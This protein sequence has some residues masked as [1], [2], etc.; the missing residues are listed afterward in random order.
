MILIGGLLIVVVIVDG[1]RRML[2]DRRNYVRMNLAAPLDDDG[3]DGGEEDVALYNPELPNGGARTVARSDAA[4]PSAAR[5][6]AAR[7]E[8]GPREGPRTVEPQLGAFD[9]DDRGPEPRGQQRE[10]AM[11]FLAQAR[12]AVALKTKFR[13]EE[14]SEPDEDLS[15]AG[16]AEPS[17]P[18]AALRVDAPQ[19]GVPASEAAQELSV[20]QPAGH[21]AEEPRPEPGRGDARKGD[22]RKGDARKGDA[23]KA[24]PRGPAP[25]EVLVINVI[26]RDSNGFNGADLLEVLMA[27]DVRFGE[28]NIFHRHEGREGQGPVQFSVANLVKPGTFDPEHMR[29]FYTP[30]VSMF[31]QLPGPD[32]PMLAFQCMAETAN[33]LVKNLQG[34]M[35]DQDHSVLTPQTLE[36]YRERVRDFERRRLARS[37]HRMA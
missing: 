25:Q 17:A 9:L 24:E 18:A 15:G 31:L 32:D 35:R 16:A 14:R 36:H 29:E 6:S 33:C 4:R 10:P 11:G 37:S 30:G 20:E 5:P 8:H 7:T 19:T 22:A 28:M 13:R 27:C 34:E 26:A 2:A 1:A 23:R 3:D 21:G 12:S